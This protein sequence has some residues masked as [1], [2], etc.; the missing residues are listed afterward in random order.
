MA[1]S[2][3]APPTSA[4]APRFMMRPARWR[5]NTMAH[6]D[7]KL[8]RRAA[9]QGMAGLVIS[10]YLPDGSAR[11]QSV[12]AQAFRSGNAPAPFTP[13]AFIRVGTDDTVTVLVKHIEFGQGP[14]TGL[15]TLVAE[16]MEADWSRVRAENAP[17]NTDLYKN[18]A[19]GIQGTG[20][21]TAIANSYE[22]MRNAGA[23][24][25]AM[26][27]TAAAETWRVPAGEIT[28][29]NGVVRHAASGREGRLGQFAEAASR[30]PVPQNVPLK[31]PATFRLI[32]RDDGSVKKL[33]SA[34][35]SNGS[36]QY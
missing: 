23:T 3:V 10:L 21:S 29:Q 8:T 34:A 7:T 6:D 12:A 30:V 31:D 15:A 11:S 14:L 24:A 22:Q 35:K 16:E 5:A 25:R 26:L 19:F 2:V 4:F 28:V 27:V 33:D 17:A 32:G 20:G 18:L 36:A 9:L 1:I 13:N